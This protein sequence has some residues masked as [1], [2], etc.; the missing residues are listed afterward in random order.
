M[1]DFPVEHLDYKYV[2]GCKNA[3]EVEKI[4]KLLR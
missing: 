3:S 4:L 2:R 1:S